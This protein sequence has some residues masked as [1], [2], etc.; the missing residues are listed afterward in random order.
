VTASPSS[1]TAQYTYTF[2]GWVNTC[3]NKLTWDCTITAQFD[4]TVNQYT[5]T[6]TATPAE[7]AES[8][9]WA[10]VYNYGDSVTVKLVP[11]KWYTVTAY[12]INW[13]RTE[14]TTHANTYSISQPS[15][16]WNLNIVYELDP[17]QYR[18]TFNKNWWTWTMSPQILLYDDEP[19]ALSKNLFTRTGYSF[20]WWAL[21]TTWWVIFEDEEEVK[22][23][24]DLSKSRYSINLFA[25]WELD[26]YTITYNLNWWT[27]NANNP[28]TYTIESWDITLQSPT[29][30]WYTFLW[31]TGE[32]VD[33]PQTWVIIPA[34]SYGDKTYNAVWQANTNTQYMVYHYV[35]R[36]W[37]NT[38][39]LADT[40]TKYGTSD[41]VLVLSWLARVGGFVC[42]SYDKWSL[43]WTESW[44][45]AIVAETIINPDGSTK[46]YLYYNRNKRNVTLSGDEHIERFMI[47]ED[48]TSEAVREC[49][50]EVP[51]EAIPKPWYHFVRW[52]REE[53]T[54]E[55]WERDNES[56]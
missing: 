22:N 24:L 45:W 12:M 39:D 8:I 7:W 33:T 26:N 29:R 20:T 10:W 48:E 50:S 14:V 11:L 55:E 15:L 37:Q 56:S 54:E 2:S 42:A 30:V 28:S 44:P 4:R 43:T 13:E 25:V 38:Y 31:W 36:V 49:G 1:R 6:V 34:W 27:N 23:I 19:V 16:K 5:V 51:V 32:N 17:T 3:G 18:V 40:E 52:D 47:G 53:R 41:A 21:T 9:T 35:K 46:I